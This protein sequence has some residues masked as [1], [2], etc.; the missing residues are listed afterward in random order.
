MANVIKPKNWEGYQHSLGCY[1][2]SKR[3]FLNKMKAMGCD[4]A[5][6]VKVKDT[7]PPAYQRSKWAKDMS[8]TALACKKGKKPWRPGDRFIDELR[9]R[10]INSKS[11]ENAMKMAKESQGG[12]F[13]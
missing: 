2:T 6:K 8:A 11:H 10:G 9:K 7:T 13:S 3:D 1:T 4:F 12:G 5:D